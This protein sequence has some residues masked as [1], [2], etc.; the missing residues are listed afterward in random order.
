MN[1]IENVHRSHPR[2]HGTFLNISYLD[3]LQSVYVTAILVS[4][5][6]TVYAIHNCTSHTIVDI[7]NCIVRKPFIVLAIFKVVQ[8]I[9][10]K[11][12]QVGFFSTVES[13]LCL[14]I[15]DSTCMKVI[16]HRRAR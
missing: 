8:L 4:L 13:K 12:S 10:C 3:A 5:Y 16:Q 9:H 11:C 14:M 2:K 6:Y 7:C 15:F 1:V